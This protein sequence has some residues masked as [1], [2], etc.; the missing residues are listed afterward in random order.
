MLQFTRYTERIGYAHSQGWF[1]SVRPSGTLAATVLVTADNLNRD[2]SL[3]HDLERLGAECYRWGV[4]PIADASWRQD[5]TVSRRQLEE[6]AP[7]LRRA[8]GST[9]ARYWLSAN[10]P[11]TDAMHLAGRSVLKRTRWLG[12][13]DWD[14]HVVIADTPAAAVFAS[15]F[16]GFRSGCL[17]PCSSCGALFT[18]ARSQRR[19]RR[20]PRCNTA[21]ATRERRPALAKIVGR[22]E[23]RIRKRTGVSAE[24][25]RGFLRDRRD[26]L[27][28][29]DA[30]RISCREAEQRLEALA[31]RSSRGRKPNTR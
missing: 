21:S 11:V 23:D 7:D 13:P 14:R 25:R 12:P 16:E 30:N 18:R 2:A 24:E 29:Y 28:D 4:V 26:I 3:T 27:L 8:A 9:K 17:R 19:L 15:L 10:G 31:P 1:E 20:C 6:F 5:L 22:I